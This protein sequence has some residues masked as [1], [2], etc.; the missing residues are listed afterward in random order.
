MSGQYLFVDGGYIRVVLE[1]RLKNLM[2]DPADIDIG[3]VRRECGGGNKVFFYDCVDKTQSQN[4]IARQ[5][6]V[7]SSIREADGCHVRLGE[8]R[9]SGKNKRQKEVD[10][11][12]AV[13]MLTYAHRGVMTRAVLLAGDRD[14]K[15]VVEALVQ[16]GCYVT[17]VCEKRSASADLLDA[18]DARR[19]LDIPALM[20]MPKEYTAGPQSVPLIKEVTHLTA[21]HRKGDSSSA[22]DSDAVLYKL[23]DL[24]PH[25][26]VHVYMPDGT[27]IEWKHM[28]AS[29]L[30][31]FVEAEFGPLNWKAPEE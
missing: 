17:V 19:Y 16:A 9:G 13:D 1:N 23:P 8:I 11:L 28:T 29:V 5:E 15:P 3:G 24:G 31:G 22:A 20:K 27:V 30:Y 26:V 25:E 14:F 6:K 7:L 4:D 21:D 10:V 12:L 2:C 18:A